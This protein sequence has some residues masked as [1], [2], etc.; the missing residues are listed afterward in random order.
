MD[1]LLIILAS[2]ILI[3]I[4]IL[5]EGPVRL[6]LGLVFILFSPGYT[7]LAAL[8]IK[9]G[10]LEVVRRLALSLGLSVALIVPVGFILNFTPWGINLVS[11][12]S[13]LTFFNLLASGIAYFR[14]RRLPLDERFELKLTLS[15]FTCL[16]KGGV[17]DR[18]LVGLLVLA[19]VV[20]IGTLV[21][22]LEE[23]QIKGKFTEFYILSAQG[24]VGDYPR[25]LTLGEEAEITVVVENH[26]G[27]SNNYRIE[28]KVAG[29]EV[30]E[31]GPFTLKD[32]EVW[33]RK[34]S[35]SPLKAGEKQKVEVRLYMGASEE[36]RQVLTF[37]ID[38]LP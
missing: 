6:I 36:P 38:V 17:W 31:I 15:S 4:A 23:P 32:N 27:K 8:F 22:L 10:E 7:L 11:V 14:R 35:F 20:A 12:L 24:Q 18:V 30:G 21:F 2:L 9:R 37:W 29:E 1:L 34:V 33:Q 28:V 26:E 3:P 19:V 13:F 16:L 25:T 5:S